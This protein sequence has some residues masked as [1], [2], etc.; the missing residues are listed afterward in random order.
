MSISQRKQQVVESAERF[1][2]QPVLQVD[3][4][5]GEGRASY[6]LSFGDRTV[7]ATL[8]PNFRRTHVE[9]FTLKKLSPFCSDLPQCLGVDGEILFQSDVGGARLNIEISKASRSHR[10]TLAHEAVSSIFRIHAAGRKAKLHESVPHLGQNQAWINNFVN[11]ISILQEFQNRQSTNLDIQSLCEKL[12]VRGTQFV[13]WDCRSGNAAIGQDGKLRWFDCEYSGARHGAED[14]A[15]LIGDESWPISPQDMEAIVADCFDPD[16]SQN[17]T[18]Y[19]DYMALY[20][21]FHSA[22]RLKLIISEVTRR[23][24]SSKSR[25][26]A[27][28]KA[29]AHPE[30]AAQ[31]CRVGR[32]FAQR[33]RETQTLARDFDDA[34]AF[35]LTRLTARPVLEKV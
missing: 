18:D 7:I 35:F 25:V 2:A 1:F 15:W 3:S 26:R 27:Y 17:V 28:D 8:R 24:W 10:D 4:P 14:F 11:G 31:I 23:G 21:T 22:Q 16:I 20:I 19:L 33:N 9:A 30:F 32:Y 5:G 13:K 12:A 34:E 29:G 6:R